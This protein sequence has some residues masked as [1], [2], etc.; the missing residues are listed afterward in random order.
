MFRKTK[1]IGIIFAHIYFDMKK[2]L[3]YFLFICV[4]CVNSYGFAQL[5]SG[6]G[7][8]KSNNTSFGIVSSSSK[9][10]K[11]PKS[12]DFK[13]N[14]GFKNAHREELKKIKKKQAESN[15][16]NKGI[17]T[18]ALRRK[19][20]LQKKAEQYNIGIP[21]IDKDLGVFKTNSKKLI[22]SSFD[23]GTFDGDII[24][25]SINGKKIINRF[26]LTNQNKDF[27]IPLNEGFNR[28]EIIAEEEGKLRPNTGAFKV[29]DNSNRIVIEDLWYLAKGAKVI[30]IVYREKDKKE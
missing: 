8:K 1:N 4:L 20:T 13:N 27:T 22:V 28:L 24:S 3:N 2:S 21:M 26:T 17:I 14:D 10:V 15:F 30:A 5:D 29:I 12:L 7:N 11:K 19:M 18:P 25:I 16:E 6:F 23:F 9:D